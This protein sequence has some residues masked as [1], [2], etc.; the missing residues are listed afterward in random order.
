MHSRSTLAF[1]SLAHYSLAH[2]PLP[3]HAPPL[4]RTPHPTVAN[5]SM[6]ETAAV[7]KRRISEAIQAAGGTHGAGGLQVRR[8]EEGKNT[9][10]CDLCR[11][12]VVACVT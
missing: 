2:H 9:V 7:A 8:E 5:I 4:T 12:C 10:V 3:S 11:G 6:D 1:H